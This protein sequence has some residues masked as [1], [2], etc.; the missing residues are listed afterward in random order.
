M[1]GSLK[2]ILDFCPKCGSNSLRKNGTIN[3]NKAK[4]E[5]KNCGHQFVINNTKKTVTQSQKDL[6]DKLQLAS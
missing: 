5:C 2:I 3:N 1:K 4:N 6:I